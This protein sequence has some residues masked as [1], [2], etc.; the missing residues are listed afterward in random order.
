MADNVK[1][2][3]FILSGIE[4]APAGEPEIEV[5]FRV[6]PDG[7]LHVSGKDL[8]TGNYQ[9]MTITD[10]VKLSEEEIKILLREVEQNPS[11]IEKNS[12]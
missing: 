3:G 7:I 1:L 6:D 12:S 11:S 8:R 5:R 4:P 10:S 2:G 9:E